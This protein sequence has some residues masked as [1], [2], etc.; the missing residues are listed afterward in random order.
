MARARAGEGPTLIECKT[1]R[2][3]AHTE[4]KGQPDHRPKEEV[5]PWKS[6][7][8]PDRA[9]R[10]AS[11]APAGPA[12][13]RRVEGDGQ[14]DPRAHRGRRRLRRGEPVSTAR[15]RDR[16][17]VCRTVSAR[18]EHVRH[19]RSVHPL[20]PRKRDPGPE[21]DCP[22]F[23][24]ARDQRKCTSV[25]PPRNPPHARDDLRAGRPRGGRRGDA[26]R[27][28]D[29]LHVDRRDPGAAEEFGPSARGRRR[30]PR[31]R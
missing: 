6:D 26:A 19:A 17:R 9:A 16:R 8:G 10:R 29:L 18:M 20:V 1:Y 25:S 31:A 27:S 2:W 21:R 22:R 30:S 12:H 4:R 23:P 3:R 13:R 14:R 28:D 24:L 7:A 11:Q 15:S 5:E